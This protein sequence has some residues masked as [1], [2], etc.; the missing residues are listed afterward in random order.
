[1]WVRG[2]CFVRLCAAP[3]AAGE[4]ETGAGDGNGRLDEPHQH[5]AG[6]IGPRHRPS[7]RA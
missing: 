6:G 4:M 2:F 3:N 5:D 7:D 1:M